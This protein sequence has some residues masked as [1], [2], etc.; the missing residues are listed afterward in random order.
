MRSLPPGIEAQIAKQPAR[1]DGLN[2]WIYKTALMLQGHRTP[3]EILEILTSATAGEPLQPNEI[4]RAITRSARPGRDLL[5]V[6]SSQ[7][8]AVRQSRYVWPEYDPARRE[9]VI[10]TMGATVAVLQELSP[11]ST[12]D[13]EAIL[14]LLFPGDPLLCVGESKSRF[15]TLSREELRGDLSKLALIVPSPMT[16]RTGLTQDGKESAHTLR[17]T[18]LRRFLIVEHDKGTAGEQFLVETLPIL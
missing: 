12:A 5:K 14:D 2:L 4:E 13:A 11:E 9:A 16:A 6:G 3:A 7:Q 17:A 8:H 18:G 15:A 10:A 1:G